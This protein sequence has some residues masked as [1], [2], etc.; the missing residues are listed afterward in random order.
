M[1]DD[2]DDEEGPDAEEYFNSKQ[3]VTGSSKIGP[4]AQGAVGGAAVVASLA[5][6]EKKEDKG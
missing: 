6:A 2:D 5:T 1:E 4:G 3:K